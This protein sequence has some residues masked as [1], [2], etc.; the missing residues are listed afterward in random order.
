MS[1][2]CGD[3]HPCGWLADKDGNINCPFLQENRHE[4]NHICI[5]GVAAL[6]ADGY[7]GNDEGELDTFV[8]RTFMNAILAA[9]RS[10]FFGTLLEC[11][12]KDLDG[13][14]D[15]FGLKKVAKN[16]GETDK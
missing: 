15:R 6:S 5:I 13:W 4:S 16:V 11:H 2:R 7:Y 12:Q 9:K 14:L 3:C 8:V 10:G 1:E